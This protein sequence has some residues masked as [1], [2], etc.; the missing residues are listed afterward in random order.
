VLSQLFNFSAVKFNLLQR[1]SFLFLFRFSFI[2]GLL[3][4][5]SYLASSNTLSFAAVQ[6]FF[7]FDF[8]S[9]FWFLALILHALWF[10]TTSCSS[11]G[12]FSFLPVVS[13]ITCVN[14]VL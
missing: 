13:L 6:G 10:V 3:T 4:F 11:H 1:S 9:R 12:S 7:C 2:F 8:L 14:E 5:N